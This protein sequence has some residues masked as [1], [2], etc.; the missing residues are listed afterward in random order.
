MLRTAYG[1]WVVLNEYSEH[2]DQL[3]AEEDEHNY[4]PEFMHALSDSMS[5][6]SCGIS[7]ASLGGNS[8]TLI[9]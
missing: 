6:S 8:G 5:M 3:S 9:N 2:S 7:I 4:Q 1:H